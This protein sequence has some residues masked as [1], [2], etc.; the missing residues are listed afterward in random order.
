MHT[1]CDKSQSPEI[2]TMSDVAPAVRM[3]DLLKLLLVILRTTSEEVRYAKLVY[4][5]FTE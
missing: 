2:T 3:H 5:T 4:S 1:D